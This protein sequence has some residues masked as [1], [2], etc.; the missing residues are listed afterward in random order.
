MCFSFFRDVCFHDIRAC[1]INV[2]FFIGARAEVFVLIL[3]WTERQ[4][5]FRA[6]IHAISAELKFFMS[7]QRK[8]YK[9]SYCLKNV[10]NI[11]FFL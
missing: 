8:M 9:N 10:D 5:D 11:D 3:S 2:R 7:F 6:V 4:L 1:S